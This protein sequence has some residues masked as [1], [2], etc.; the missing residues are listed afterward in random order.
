VRTHRLLGVL[1]FAG[2]AASLIGPTTVAAATTLPN[3][4][5]ATTVTTPTCDEG[6]WPASVQGVPTNLVAGARGGD[7]LWHDATGWHLRVTH[8]GTTAV[9]FSG[10]I[11]ANE[12]LAVVGVRLE[13]GDTFSLSPDH[14]TVTYRFINH[15]RIDGLD[16]RTACASRIGFRGLM[17]GVKLFPCLKHPGQI[18][19]C[20]W[21]RWAGRGGALEWGNRITRRRR[22]GRQVDRRK[23]GGR[24]TVDDGMGRVG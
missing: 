11:T 12:P 10:T 24:L 21:V 19:D 22:V 4:A 5:T 23:R 15:G 20:L 9:R 2:L 6:R 13:R 7:Y 1:A 18:A 16:I 3:V 8:Q 14:R 17:S